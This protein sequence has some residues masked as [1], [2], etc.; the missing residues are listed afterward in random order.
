MP[1]SRN[2]RLDLSNRFVLN[3]RQYATGL[4]KLSPA[5]EA[6][7]ATMLLD[8]FSEDPENFPALQTRLERFLAITSADD[9]ARLQLAEMAI[10]PTQRQARAPSIL[11]FSGTRG[12]YWG[13]WKARISTKGLSQDEQRR[14]RAVGVTSALPDPETSHDFFEWLAAQ[15]AAILS[16]HIPCVLRHILH[17][18]GP[19]QWAQT[20]T[21]TPCIPVRNRLGVRLVSLRTAPRA[22]VYLPDAGAIGD[23]V[24]HKD[25]SV[26]LA[27]DR[28]MEV[29]EPTTE[30]LR[31]LG[32]RS[33]REALDE[34]VSV[35]G[36][37]EIAAAGEDLLAQFHVLL[38]RRF[39]RT[40]LKRLNDLGVESEL[41]RRDWHDR[42]SQITDICFADEVHATYR[43]RSKLYRD[44]VD[45][46][47]DAMSHVFWM[48]RERRTNL[49]SLYEAVAKQLVLTS[50]ARPIDLLALE[51]ALELEVNDPS[52][53]PPAGTELD[54]INDNI[55][56]KDDGR[57]EHSD[58]ADSEPGEAVHGHSP[59]EPD[60]SRNVPKPSPIPPNFPKDVT[61]PFSAD[62][63]CPPGRIRA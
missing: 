25:R 48:R 49:S 28:V 19:T 23:A 3:D 58:G 51:G 53:A 38:S 46:G 22:P 6:P 34:P 10:I 62:R 41:V 40:L 33:L 54:A 18:D 2:D 37:G 31:D 47:F 45:A 29:R 16:R 4:D 63:F 27:I 39:R 57:I 61:A 17:R 7:T 36:T 13:D 35:A 1:N 32:V 60:A 44:E 26:S 5:L 59:F 21:D 55:T 14:Y 9:H 12:D 11:A 43:F 52:F 56:E 30:R 8:T 20:F 42:L 15:N 50:A 24:I